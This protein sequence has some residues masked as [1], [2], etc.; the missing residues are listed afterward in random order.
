MTKP[1]RAENGLGGL[2]RGGR[3]IFVG[4]VA[5]TPGET[6][7]RPV[8]QFGRPARRAGCAVWRDRSEVR[9]RGIGIR[10]WGGVTDLGG[11]HRKVLDW[12]TLLSRMKWTTHPAPTGEIEG[13][14]GPVG[15][16][17]A[18]EVVRDQD[19]DECRDR[20]RQQGADRAIELRAGQD[21]DE[22]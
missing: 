22:D 3:L 5:S 11:I 10:R 12:S 13:A 9:R 16:P 7:C 4:G 2:G 17:A 1:S 14:A 8:E 6:F 21:G 20:D 18:I 19:L 15:A